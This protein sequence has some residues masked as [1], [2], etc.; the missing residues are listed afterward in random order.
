M[1]KLQKIVKKIQKYV[2]LI[3]AKR[4][5]FSNKINLSNMFIEFELDV[6]S[7]FF[8]PWPFWLA[9]KANC[10]PLRSLEERRRR[11]SKFEF[12][13]EFRDFSSSIFIFNHQINE[14]TPCRYHVQDPKLSKVKVSPYFRLFFP[15][16][17][18][19]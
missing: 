11:P 7:V 8:D 15:L 12:R 10:L 13:I 1:P 4:I 19:I 17:S 3:I 16:K 2:K 9:L 6:C 14:R 18:E 5:K